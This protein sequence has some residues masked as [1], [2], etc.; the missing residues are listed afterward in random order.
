MRQHLLTARGVY[1][2]LTSKLSN[3]GKGRPQ[4]TFLSS[5]VHYTQSK[6]WGN[7]LMTI[8][9]DVVVEPLFSTEQKRSRSLSTL[10]NRTAAHSMPARLY[11][12]LEDAM[13]EENFMDAVIY[14]AA[15]L[16][17]DV[18][19]LSLHSVLTDYENSLFSSDYWLERYR[20]F[21][22]RLR[23]VLNKQGNYNMK[24]LMLQAAL[25]VTMLGLHALYGDRM[26]DSEALK[27][28]RLSRV[29]SIGVLWE[30]SL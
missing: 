16:N 25:R 14:T 21:L 29:C 10:M 30:L 2:L 28:L 12:A 4:S 19:P 17:Q 13:D 20:D 22:L 3:E 8:L 9:P 11:H 18:N 7:F 5:T 24:K 15:Q 6:F 27:K 26:H 23:P 1:S